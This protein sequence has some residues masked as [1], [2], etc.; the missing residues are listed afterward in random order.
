V[1]A[2]REGLLAADQAVQGRGHLGR[3]GRRG[4]EL[5]QVDGAERL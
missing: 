5:V 1:A 2:R 3:Q 4:G